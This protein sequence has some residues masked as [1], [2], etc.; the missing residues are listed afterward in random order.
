MWKTGLKDSHA[1]N[2]NHEK[3]ICFFLE[4]C[5]NKICVKDLA[6]GAGAGIF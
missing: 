2:L 1:S 5:E 3:N 6:L 4:Q